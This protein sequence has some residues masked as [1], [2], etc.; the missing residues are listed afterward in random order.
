M[1]QKVR[2]TPRGITKITPY[3]A[4]IGRKANTPL[5]KIAT[6]SLPSNLNW[7]NAKHACL[8]RKNLMHPSSPAEILY[9][10]QNWS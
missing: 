6:N 9:D 7:E 2:I 4:L 3:E 1:F 5:S 8:D 10:L